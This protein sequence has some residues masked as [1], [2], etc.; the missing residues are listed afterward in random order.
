LTPR[1]ELFRYKGKSSIS[2]APLVFKIMLILPDPTLTFKN[3]EVDDFL[4]YH[5]GG[6]ELLEMFITS[7]TSDANDTQVEVCSLKYPYK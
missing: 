4:K 3:V 5:D 6:M 2:L 7:S 1:E